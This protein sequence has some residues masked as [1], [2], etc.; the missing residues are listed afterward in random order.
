M[1]IFFELNFPFFFFFCS[2][3]YVRHWCKFYE[4]VIEV[5][6]DISGMGKYVGQDFE[7][8]LYSSSKTAKEVDFHNSTFPFFYSRQGPQTEHSVV[9]LSHV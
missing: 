9:L 7:V 6:E 4:H 8:V 5:K 2:V 1:E 3:K